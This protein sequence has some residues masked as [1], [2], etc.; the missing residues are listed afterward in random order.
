MK[1]PLKSVQFKMALKLLLLSQFNNNALLEGQGG[2]PAWLAGGPIPQQI[3]RRKS[4]VGRTSGM[5]SLFPVIGVIISLVLF[6]LGYYLRVNAAYT[7]GIQG[8]GDVFLLIYALFGKLS[9]FYS[10]IFFLI[11]IA[12]F[13]WS[14]I[15]QKEP[16]IIGKRSLSDL[17]KLSWGDF[18]EYVIGL[19]QQLGY[20]P[21]GS[22]ALDDEYADLRLKRG[23]RTS[24]VCCKKYYV[25]KIPLSMVLEFYVAML[26]GPS[27]EKGYFIT[28]GSFSHEAR[29]FALD[30]PLVLIDGE[31]LMDF[32]RIAESIDA[33]R[34]RSSLQSNLSNT[35]YTCPMCGAHMLLRTVEGNSHSVVQFWGCSAYP[36]CKGALRKEQE[37][38]AP[39]G[40]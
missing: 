34:G 32:A 13:I 36:A 25:R 30:K 2:K 28:T 24:L 1:N 23:A 39:S 8:D 11:S 35:G 4:T 27:L 33:A 10:G 16:F 17:K 40:Y 20:S 6:A 21:E 15:R 12:G 7:A 9:Y 31:R 38:F 22:G 5:I 14:S 3:M 29:K 37:D 19:F 26:K 18:R